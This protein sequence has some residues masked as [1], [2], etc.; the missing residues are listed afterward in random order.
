VIC[1]LA[2]FAVMIVTAILR[3]SEAASVYTELTL[4]LSGMLVLAG[5]FTAMAMII[6]GI[7]GAFLLLVIG[8][9]QTVL[10]AVSDLNIPLLM[11]FVFGAGIGV[12][13]GAALVRFL[14]AKAPKETYGA[15]LGL[16]AGSI[17]ALYPGGFGEGIMIFLSPASLLAG[18]ALSFFLGNNQLQ[19]DK[20]T[21][22]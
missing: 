18:G 9:Y 5:A 20:K 21:A 4:P 12:F 8:F 1:A 15:V 10:K 2:A 13:L 22:L 16:V 19:K 17:I 7:S 3:P 11:P 14:L 6:P